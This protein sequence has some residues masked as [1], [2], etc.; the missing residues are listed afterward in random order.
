MNQAGSQLLQGNEDKGP[1]MK[2][3]MGE[4]QTGVGADGPTVKE[5]IDIES[6]RPPA[7]AAVTAETLL[8]CQ[9]GIEESM[10]RELCRHGK[11]TVQIGSLPRRSADGS[12]FIES[13]TFEDPDSGNPVERGACA[14]KS[15][16]AIA[17]IGTEPEI[18][19]D[20]RGRSA[21]HGR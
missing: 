3:R 18:G 11:N 7:F 6:P 10:G 13:R 1:L 2:S 12:G 9:A 19:R 8:H 15:G 20:R 5:K 4:G 21:V 14:A 17:E 16:E